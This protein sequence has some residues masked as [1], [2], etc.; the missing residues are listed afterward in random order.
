MPGLVQE[1]LETTPPAPERTFTVSH[2]KLDLDVD[3]LCGTFAGRTTLTIS[4]QSRVLSQIGLN[5]RQCKVRKVAV[6][7][8]TATYSYRDPYERIVPGIESTVHQH[9]QVR[10][11]L[12]EHLKAPPEPELIITIPKSVR[13]DDLDPLSVEAPAR[14]ASF[15]SGHYKRESDGGSI[16]D[17][18]QSAKSTIEQTARYT[19]IN[20]YIEYDVSR[21]QDGIQFIGCEEGDLRYPH[22]YTKNSLLPG[23]ACS[24]FPC[25]DDC[26]SRCTWEVS[27][28]C[29]RTLGDALACALPFD[30][31]PLV[32]RRSSTTSLKRHGCHRDVSV[33]LAYTDE[34]KALDIIVIGSGDTTDEIIDPQDAGKKTTT[35]MVTSTISP[36]HLGFVIGP[37]ERIDLAEFREGNDQERVGQ[38][39][40]PLSGFCLPG[41][42]DEVRNTCLPVAKAIDFF[43]ITYGSFPFSNYGLCF[44]D[45][46][47]PDVLNTACLSI[48][49]T[50]LLFPENVLDPIDDVTREL[51]HALAAQWVGVDIVPQTPREIWAT[52]GI[53]YFMADMF[54]KKLSG[55]NE[56]RYRQ[57]KAADRVAELDQSRPTLAD[58]GA[59]IGI[60]PI[61]LE[62]MK[63]KAPLVLFILDR[64]LTKSSGSSGIS[65][66]I[67]RILLNAKVGELP[68]GAISNAYFTKTCERLG[69]AK[70]DPF[71]NQWIFGSGCPKFLVTQRFNKKKLVVE[72][73]ID[74]KQTEVH[75]PDLRPDTLMR[76]VKEDFNG[77]FAG[78][79]QP[80]F[81]GPMTIRI[82]EA[83]GTPYEHII[84]VREAKTRIEIPYNTKY[85]R[86]KR[87][88]RQKDKVMEAAGGDYN[89]DETGD[90]LLYC[91][92]DVLQSEE[93]MKAW[94]LADWSPDDVND[95]SNEHY[96]WV[97]MDADFEWICQMSIAMKGYMYLSQLQQDRDVVAQLQS[98]QSLAH[99][100]PHPF[101][102]TI[103][104]RT[105]MDP[106]YFH[107]IR[108]EAA[109]ALAKHG[110]EE[111]NYIGLYHLEKAFQEL[112]C[113][114]DSLMPQPNDFYDR[115]TYFLQ[116][117]IPKAISKVRD[118]AKKSPYRV[119]NFLYEKLR[120][121]DN[122]DNDLS[123]AHYLSTLM[124]ALA[125]AVAAQPA[126]ESNNVDTD[127]FDNFDVEPTDD[128]PEF[129][130]SCLNE[131]D[132]HR[133]IDEWIPSHHNLLSRTA[134]ECK[135]ILT[136][137]HTFPSPPSEFLQYT[138]DETSAALRISALSGVVALGGGKQ[139]QILHFLISIFSTDPSP[140]IR[141][142]TLQLLHQAISALAISP[143][144]FE[145]STQQD[146][147]VI[148]QDASTEARQ[149]LLARRKTIPGALLALKIEIGDDSSIQ[150]ALWRAI[151]SPMLS[152]LEITHLLD[153]CT[154]L[155]EPEDKYQIVFK[156]PRFWKCQRDI[157]LPRTGADG[158][159][160]TCWMRFSATR[161]RTT[162][163]A[164]LHRIFTTQANVAP[165][166]APISHRP[167]LKLKLGGGGGF[168]ASSTP[169][170]GTPA[171]LT[172][173][174]QT[175]SV[176]SKPKLI[177]KA[178]N[179]LPNIATPLPPMLE[180]APKPPTPKPPTP[181]PPASKKWA[182][183]PKH[184]SPPRLK[185][186][187]RQAS[188]ASAG[189]VKQ[190]DGID[191]GRSPEMEG[192][193]RMTIKLK[194]GPGTKNGA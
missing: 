140:Y 100:N 15:A 31:Q 46:L 85:K 123:D 22:A 174:L 53:S 3:I 173:I 170:V 82:H 161:V 9:H 181:K 81:Q 177:F 182:G 20:V 143:L 61:F 4:P 5:C 139:R 13:I 50:R 188:S 130:R 16:G 149:A 77:V 122:T 80:A 104:V 39:A 23:A 160:P 79:L 167:T 192:K 120:F 159:T 169:T 138:S 109:L 110:V 107:G 58:H 98:I 111:L 56:Y 10:E 171:P 12:A 168:S 1:V 95:M 112:F 146:G 60:D 164:P 163:R 35:F 147:L 93:E 30:D 26:T 113:L 90:S 38:T 41:R 178:P 44:V 166:L 154:I 24:L 88:K 49:S 189:A 144:D 152:L 127:F 118:P 126:I 83:D 142:H 97:R 76:E 184:N 86:L 19:P 78:D 165:P 29:A 63:L 116:C 102:S 45:D 74:Q 151:Q 190:E 117:A 108:T 14:V 194:I 150:E 87:G 134:L 180:A 179:R 131:M 18:P 176:A 48:C 94:R 128:T 73:T 43:T 66:I 183:T 158:R 33:G 155:Y 145:K 136:Q 34:D 37:F 52:I 47:G 25:V 27:I 70:L 65:R 8:T 68:N 185:F 103:F 175:P 28:K 124:L 119:R 89:V 67:S 62:F 148:E 72:I 156:Y 57:K 106:R 40:V 11:K 133:R 54:M 92:G 153:I 191:E 125:E 32:N 129:R 36:Q 115:P 59:C 137:S 17:I 105:L 51:V 157:S 6:N 42:A 172:S 193:K 84:E 132:R 96:E 121:N 2:Q 64:R 7:G 55:N 187:N 162:P 21:S 71:F 141:S 75:E 101:V 91:L 186:G 135:R 69:H 114:P 99:Q